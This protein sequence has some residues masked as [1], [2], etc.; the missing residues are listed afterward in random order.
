L[1]YEYRYR[2]LTGREWWQ[3]LGKRLVDVSVSL[4]AIIFLA[5]LFPLIWLT[6]YLDSR[7]PVIFKQERIG[8]HGRVFTC[9]KIRTMYYGADQRVHQRAIER[10]W[11]GE[12]ISDDPDSHFKLA[13]DKRVTQTGRWLRMTS[14]DEL[15]QLINVLRGEMSI[16]GPRPAIAYELKHYQDWH[17]ERHSVKPGITGLWQVRGRG[18]LDLNEMMKLDVEYART[19][20]VWLDLKIIALTVPTVLKARGAK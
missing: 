6:V 15:P 2:S 10:V 1:N 13:D 20:S 5:P 8:R 16:V 14:M 19:W 3:N 12:R 7:G 11:A 4:V 17:H 18:G 9:L